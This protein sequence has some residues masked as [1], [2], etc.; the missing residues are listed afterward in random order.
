MIAACGSDGQAANDAPAAD[1]EPA[2]TTALPTVPDTTANLDPDERELGR[3]VSLAEEY[4]LGDLLELDIEPVASTATV[5]AVGF[6]G[7]DEYDTSI[8][9]LPQTTLNLE[10]LASL[11]PDTIVTLQFW[12]DQI[13]HG[14]LDAIADVIVIPDEL[15]GAERSEALGD[16]VGRPERG[17]AVSAELEF[18][19]PI[20]E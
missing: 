15:S 2:A 9:V 10:Y 6:Q 18:A 19:R 4:I 13:G 17:A 1:D 3:V 11:Q 8:E 20:G 7:L 16:L 12:I 5:D 14:V